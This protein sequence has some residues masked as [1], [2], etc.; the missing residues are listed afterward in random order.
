MLWYIP[1]IPRFKRLFSIEKDAENLRWHAEGRKK[2][3]LLKHSV[4]SPEWKN[5]YMKF[6]SFGNEVR[7][8]RLGLCTDGMNPFDTL[9]A[10]HSTWPI[11][12]VIYNLPPWM[13]MKRKY[14]ML[15]LL[16]TGL[17]QPENDIDV[18][19]EPLVDDLRRIWDEGV[20]V[21]DAHK[22]EMFT[23]HATIM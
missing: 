12:L 2:N 6:R 17:R 13:C 1:I 14:M 18:Y 22:N 16:I 4:D 23:L 8:L 11:L 10:Q 3:S 15:S 7:N 20:S 19:L 21:F 5:I 9:S